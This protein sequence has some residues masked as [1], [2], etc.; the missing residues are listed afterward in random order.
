MISW[1]SGK[2]L[3]HA[4]FSTFDLSDFQ[5]WLQGRKKNKIAP[6]SYLM[7]DIMVKDIRCV[8]FELKQQRKLRLD[9]TLTVWTSHDFYARVQG[10][11]EDLF[12][13]E[14]L[15]I[16]TKTT[17]KENQPVVLAEKD[18]EIVGKSILIWVF[19]I[20][21]LVNFKCRKLKLKCFWTLFG[22]RRTKRTKGH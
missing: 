10:E 13:A 17:I 22:N 21:D 11:Y 8:V 1:K 14:P 20:L 4:H 5:F 15:H 9:I 18:V 3:L 2:S 12:S 19:G 16:R 6:N 7:I